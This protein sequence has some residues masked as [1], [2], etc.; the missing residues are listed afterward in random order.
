MVT[1]LCMMPLGWSVSDAPQCPP[2]EGEPID[3]KTGS[4]AT[5]ESTQ[6]KVHLCCFGISFS[7]Y[8]PCHLS[9]LFRL[10][11]SPRCAYALCEC[12]EASQFLLIIARFPS[13]LF[14]G[15]APATLP[16][17]RDTY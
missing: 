7:Q 13:I 11:H 9:H 3:Y 1:A 8:W 4:P 15:W 14:P 17:T 10:S 2:K 6:T 16:K 12:S 5:H